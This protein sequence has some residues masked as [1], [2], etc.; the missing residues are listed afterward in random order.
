MILPWLRGIL[1]WSQVPLTWSIVALNLLVFLVIQDVD[2]HR[3]SDQSFSSSQDLVFTGQLYLQFTSQKSE[4]LTEA[5]IMVLGSRA[6]HDRDFLNAASSFQFFGDQV[7]IKDWREKIYHFSQDFKKRSTWVF[8]LSQDSQNNLSWLTY[9]FV[10]A[11]FFHLMSNML[12]LLF[13]GSA[14]E[15]MAGSV[16]MMFLY[17]CSGIAGGLGFFALAGENF[18]PVVG[19]SGALTGVMAFYFVIER[20]KSVPFF[21]FLSPVREFYGWL[22][23]PK[24]ALLPI[25]FVPDVVGFLST[26]E[27]L[28]S[29]V[30]Y[31]AHLG[32][33]LF[34]FLLG[35]FYR[36]KSA[37]NIILT[38]S[39]RL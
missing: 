11:G 38:D 21:Y 18:V 5:E 6:L 24:W 8:G 30:A 26:P 9:Q 23:L 2:K 14:V 7:A 31:T 25:V 34:G 36:S 27:E 12:M 32:G 17:L 3:R 10:H 39:P 19:A 29:G 15:L 28:G 37:T 4:D 1:S 35:L 20:R 22:H 13:F 33:A 16:W